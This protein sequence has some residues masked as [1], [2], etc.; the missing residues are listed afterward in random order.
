[1]NKQAKI[2]KQNTW[3]T[4]TW[5]FVLFQLRTRCA[6]CS[7]WKIQFFFR[8]RFYL[9]AN[10]IWLEY[11]SCDR[12]IEFRRHVLA[13]CSLY[14]NSVSVLS[15]RSHTCRPTAHKNHR[16]LENT[17]RKNWKLLTESVDWDEQ[18]IAFEFVW[19]RKRF[20]WVLCID[21]LFLL[22]VFLIWYRVF[23]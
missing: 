20:L 2:R 11:R 19:T 8:F 14:K 3:P 22:C 18:I 17:F 4:A 1:M 9:T 15:W 7:W 12:F 6:H 21:G 10:N 13:R 16:C 23:L 5:A